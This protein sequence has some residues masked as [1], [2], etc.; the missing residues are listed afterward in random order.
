[1]SISFVKTTSILAAELKIHLARQI[2]KLTKVVRTP[3]CHQSRCVQQELSSFT[4]Q[5]QE[6]IKKYP[7]ITFC[8]PQMPPNASL[9]VNCKWCI[10]WLS[11][12]RKWVTWDLTC[13]LKLHVSAAYLETLFSYLKSCSRLEKRIKVTK[14]RMTTVLFSRSSTMWEQMWW[15]FSTSSTVEGLSPS[16]FG[17]NPITGG[18]KSGFVWMQTNKW[19]VSSSQ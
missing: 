15:W 17:E 5:F 16:G 4:H 10:F 12:W 13:V 1:M 14:N 2:K 3:W 6:K 11:F 19:F 9:M 7:K 8:I 18:L